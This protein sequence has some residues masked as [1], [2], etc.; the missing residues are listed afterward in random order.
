MKL[1]SFNFYTSFALATCLSLGS[2]VQAQNPSFNNASNLQENCICPSQDEIKALYLNAQAILK[3]NPSNE[4]AIKNYNYWLDRIFLS[5][6]DPLG[7]PLLY[8]VLINKIFPVFHRIGKESF[9]KD[10]QENSRDWQDLKS[11]LEHYKPGTE[12]Y[13]ALS[14]DWQKEFIDHIYQ[15]LE[16]GFKII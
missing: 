9:K 12:R 16:I 6:E 15:I 11:F 8:E 5:F 3:M 14:N 10:F 4:D 2:S 13:N 7:K 1:L